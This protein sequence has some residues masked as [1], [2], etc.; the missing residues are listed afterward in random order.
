MSLDERHS[1]WLDDEL[2]AADAA[3][4]EA[5]LAADPAL[6]AEVEYWHGHWRE[7]F[8]TIYLG[9]GTPSALSLA[10]LQGLLAGLRGGLPFEAEPVLCMEANPE[11]VTP[12][13]VAGSVAWSA[14][15]SGR[16][17]IRDSQTNPGSDESTVS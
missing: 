4:V 5:E 3:A 12:A 1:A 9:G 14:D 8:D 13:S 11:D 6:A 7:P 17:K 2:D 16:R 10:G 15:P